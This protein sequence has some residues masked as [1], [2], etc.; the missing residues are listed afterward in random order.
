MLWIK[1]WLCDTDNYLYKVIF[2]LISQIILIRGSRD[3][4]R[5]PNSLVEPKDIKLDVKCLLLLKNFFFC[6]FS[7]IIY[8]VVNFEEE[9]FSFR[10]IKIVYSF[11]C[12]AALPSPLSFIFLWLLNDKCVLKRQWVFFFLSK[13]GILIIFR[14]IC[15]TFTIN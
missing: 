7:K 1:Y 4:K 10:V 11:I 14:V 3:R 8:V 15:R 13:T 5:K 2:K 12:F 9:C 6:F